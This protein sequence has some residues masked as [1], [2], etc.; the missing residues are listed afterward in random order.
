MAEACLKRRCG[1]LFLRLLAFFRIKLFLPYLLEAA[2]Q[3]VNDY[4]MTVFV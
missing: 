2:D 4:P 3:A 1:R